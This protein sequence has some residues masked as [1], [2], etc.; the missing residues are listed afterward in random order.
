MTVKESLTFILKKRKYV[1]IIEI[2]FTEIYNFKK[3]QK[4]L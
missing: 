3:K 1:I 2:Y 4:A